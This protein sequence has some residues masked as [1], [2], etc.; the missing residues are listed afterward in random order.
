MRGDRIHDCP[1]AGQRVG[2]FGR[3]AHTCQRKS[4]ALGGPSGHT[5]AYATSCQSVTAYIPACRRP[6]PI[7]WHSGSVDKP[8][9]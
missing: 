3:V 9:P 7:V 2:A 5:I 4:T 1:A 8:G 6:I